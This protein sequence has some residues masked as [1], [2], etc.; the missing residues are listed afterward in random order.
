[1]SCDFPFISEFLDIFLAIFD[2]FIHKFQ[3]TVKFY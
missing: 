3:R 1:M 2:N